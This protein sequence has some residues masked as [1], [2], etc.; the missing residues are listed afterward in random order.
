MKL[1]FKWFRLL[2]SILVCNSNTI[3][4]ILNSQSDAVNSC[5]TTKLYLN[6]NFLRSINCGYII[7]SVDIIGQVITVLINFPG[8]PLWSVQPAEK[9]RLWLKGNTLPHL[10]YGENITYRRIILLIPRGAN[11]FFSRVLLLNFTF[12]LLTLKEGPLHQLWLR[13]SSWRYTWPPQKD[14][15]RAAPQDQLSWTLTD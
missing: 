9:C 11:T 7:Q 8:L 1:Y 2:N 12:W 14:R 6:F 10:V 5:G 4:M 15:N 13:A 3:N